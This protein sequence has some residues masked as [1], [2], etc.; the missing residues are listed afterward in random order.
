MVDSVDVFALQQLKKFD[1]KK[2][3]TTTKE[4]LDLGD[5]PQLLFL[6]SGHGSVWGLFCLAHDARSAANCGAAPLRRVATQ[7]SFCNID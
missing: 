5:D 3:E 1:R 4:G 7:T 2:L 6:A